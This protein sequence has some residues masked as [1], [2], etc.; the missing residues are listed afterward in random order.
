MIHN[1]NSQNLYAW[2]DSTI[3]LNWLDGNPRRFKTYV[4]NRISNI[5]ELIPSIH[6]KHVNGQ[7]NPADCASRGLYPSELLDHSLWWKGPPWLYLDSSEWPKQ[8]TL[9]A[10][11]PELSCEEK[12]SLHST[13]IEKT[14][15][16]PID[17]YSSFNK[18][19]RITTLVQRFV[20]NCQVP[21]CDRLVSFLTVQELTSAEHYWVKFVQEDHFLTDIETIKSGKNLPDSSSLLSL[22]PFLDRFG[23]L[24]VGGREQLSSRPFTSRH[25]A[26]LHGSHHIAKLIIHSEHIRLLHAGPTLLSTSLSR[27][28]HIIGCKRFVRS[29]TRGCIVC[30]RNTTRP[31]P[32][33]MGRL[34]IERLTPG[35]VFKSVGVDFAGP[36]YVKYGYVRK[37]QVVKAYICVYVSLTVKAVHLEAVSDLTTEAFIASL[38]RFIARRGKPSLIKSDHGTNFVGAARELKEIVDFLNTAKTRQVISDFCSTQNITWDFIPEHAPRFGGIW[39]AAV[40]SLKTHLKRVTNNVKFTFEELITILSQIEAC[41]NSRPLV[42]ITCDDDG[43]EAL[44]PGHFLIGRPIEALPD[45]SSPDDSISTLRR[46]HLCQGVIRHFWTRWSNEYLNSL[47]RFA[48][49]NHPSKNVKEGDIVVIQE[50]NM[51]PTRWPLARVEKVYY[52]NDGLARVV[53]VKT[54]SGVYRRPIT[55][56]APLLSEQTT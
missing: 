43:I 31:L 19:K 4:G 52:G 6:W 8:A 25:P 20:R 30:R 13:L 2:T 29:V 39:E 26:I 46:W 37:P 45:V 27:R 28:F 38:R 7:E 3:V 5:I 23:V 53:N 41:L 11:P 10:V 22:H 48:K 17:R 12:V 18:L 32:Q 35:P 44:T 47:R 40:K 24:R 14:P 34:P 42:L 54:R 1:I 36:V 15:V 51:V 50:D 33:L 16:I 49:W 9:Q 56:I 21:T 55:K